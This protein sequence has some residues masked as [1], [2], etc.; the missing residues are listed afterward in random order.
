LGEFQEGRAV[1]NRRWGSAPS[2]VGLFAFN[3]NAGI[4]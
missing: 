3:T 4:S 1:R 2:P